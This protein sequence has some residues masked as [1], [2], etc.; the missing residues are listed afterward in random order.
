MKNL[1][2]LSLATLAVLAGTS[3]LHSQNYNTQSRWSNPSTDYYSNPN[4]QPNMGMTNHDQFAS[5]NKQDQA[6]QGF[7][8]Y[9]QNPMSP[10]QQ[11]PSTMSSNSSQSRQPL[12]WTD[13]EIA[14]KIRWAIRGDKKLSPLAKSVEITVKNA[15]VYLTGTVAS[16]T[17]REQI[18]KLARQVSGVKSI[19]NSLMITTDKTLQ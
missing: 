12:V 4:Y 3:L 11:A 14:Q 6:S 9:N 7:S 16:E 8:Q 2:L 13:N 15:N 19:S 18:A 1:P 10:E 5:G 17:E